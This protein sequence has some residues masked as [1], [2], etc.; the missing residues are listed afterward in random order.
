MGKAL[1][2]YKPLNLFMMGAHFMT[3][4]GNVCKRVTADTQYK[5]LLCEAIQLM[6]ELSDIKG[7]DLLQKPAKGPP[8]FF[9][10]NI[11]YVD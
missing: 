4:V 9:A 6:G 10:R 11:G 2:L 8:G 7:S 3:S 1:N 5:L